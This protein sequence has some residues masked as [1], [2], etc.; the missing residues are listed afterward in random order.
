MEVPYLNK[1]EKRE[2]TY[3]NQKLIDK[4]YNT[5]ARRQGG[6][7]TFFRGILPKSELENL[8]FFAEK[9]VRLV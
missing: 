7:N 3:K 1:F 5:E 2:T 6:I 8:P 9:N 4:A